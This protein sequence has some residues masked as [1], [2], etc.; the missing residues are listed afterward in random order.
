VLL[1]QADVALRPHDI[2]A[3]LQPANGWVAP[4]GPNSDLLP[5]F[6]ELARRMVARV[7]GEDTGEFPTFRD[8]VASQRVLDAAYASS[9]TNRIVTLSA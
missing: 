9:D 3:A 5:A 8:G 2:D 4:V 7:R 1:S 6:V